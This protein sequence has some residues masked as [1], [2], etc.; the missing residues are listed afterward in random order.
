[1]PRLD[2]IERRDVVDN[3]RYQEAFAES[4]VGSLGLEDAIQ[5]CREN[6]WDGVL[7]F[8]LVRKSPEERA[9]V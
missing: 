6:C 8:V 2:R 7:R 4:L 5:A 9:I 3:R 1:M